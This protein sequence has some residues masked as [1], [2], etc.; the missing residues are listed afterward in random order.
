MLDLRYDP[1]NHRVLFPV[2]GPREF[3]HGGRGR[4]EDS[5]QAGDSWLPLF[6][7][8]GRTILLKEQW[9]PKGYPKVRDYA[10]LQKRKLILGEHLIREDDRPLLIVEGLFALAH[11]ISC[12]VRDYCDPVAVMGS[13]IG[14][15]K[16]DLIVGWDKPCFLLFD[17]DLAGDEG[18]FGPIE[19]GQHVGGGAV[20]MLRGEVPTKLCIYP[21]GVEDTDL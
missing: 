7:F 3:D 9:P 4:P 13:H 15:E 10:G 1:E 12:G 19:N 2:Y 20:D 18:M 14:D 8:T 17:N 11:S 6:G 5:S 16:R 21:E